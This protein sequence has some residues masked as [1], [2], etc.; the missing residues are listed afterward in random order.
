MTKFSVGDVVRLK[1][2][3]PKMTVIRVDDPCDG[4]QVDAV[5]FHEN[6]ELR[7]ES[8]PANVLEL[9]KA[10]EPEPKPPV[11]HPPGIKEYEKMLKDVAEFLR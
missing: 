7:R 2:G 4:I 3:G 1:S 11:A 8:I 6:Y 10:S 9:V 5:W